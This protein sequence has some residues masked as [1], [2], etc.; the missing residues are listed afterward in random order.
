MAAVGAVGA[1]GCLP[2]PR[3]SDMTRLTNCFADGDDDLKATL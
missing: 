2:D 3:V 1:P